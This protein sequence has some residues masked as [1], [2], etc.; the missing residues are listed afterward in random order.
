[1]A[2]KVVTICT[3]DLTGEES[4]EATTHTFSLDGVQYEIDLAPDSY[5]QLLEAMAP[6]TKAGRKTG[7]ARK[8]HKATAVS[9]DDSAAIRAWAK[10]AGFEVSNRGRVPA[11]VR[12]AYAKAH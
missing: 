4:S 8:S 5:D 7:R 9:R 12:E 2:Q 11:A 1:M 10:E 6:F 3:D